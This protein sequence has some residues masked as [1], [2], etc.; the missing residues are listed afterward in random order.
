VHVKIDTG[1][2]RVGVPFDDVNEFA[3]RLSSLSNLKVEGI[4]TH[5]SVADDL[6]EIEITNS[7]IERLNAAVSLFREK[8]FRPE[9]IDLANSPG[10]VAHPSSRA[11]LVR[12][13]GILYGLGRDVLPAGVSKPE[14]RPVLS[15]HT[16]LA[17][18]KRFPSGSGI[19]YG[20]TFVT[21]RDSVIGTVPIGY[22][23]GYRRELSNRGRAIVKGVLVP[24]VGRVS[25]DWVTL[26]LTAVP[27]AAV[28]DE[29]VLIGG[30][31]EHSI[32]V[33]DLAEEIGTISYEV[34]CGISSRV[35]RRYA[36]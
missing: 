10:A 24:I 11:D 27:G 29:V 16:R 25:M 3:D 35:P 6:G 8:G 34:T 12:I 17:Q 31:G 28:G 33:E 36:G 15:L 20:R 9:I 23:D 22:H 14:I 19:G 30:Q 18:V 4:M 21:T 26:D 1:M 7:Q 32:L 2:G 5:F 13:G